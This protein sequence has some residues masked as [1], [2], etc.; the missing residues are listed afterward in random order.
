MITAEELRSL[1]TVRLRELLLDGHEIPMDALANTCFRGV[2][3]GLPRWIEKLTWKTF[4]KTF[5]QD[6]ETGVLRGWNVRL[7]QT[8]YDFPSQ[9]KH[10]R[11]GHEVTFG[12]YRVVPLQGIAGLRQG[13]LLD[14]REGGN[15]TTDPARFILDPLVAVNPGNHDLLLGRTWIALGSRVIP[16]PSYFSLERE[17]SLETVVAPPRGR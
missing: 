17:C 15:P 12:H 6:P 2:S 1:P 10:N 14:D 4:R 3:L 8:G 5:F 16:T 9:P 11:R 7:Q 13:V